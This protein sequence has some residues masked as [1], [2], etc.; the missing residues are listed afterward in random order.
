M[1]INSSVCGSIVMQYIALFPI[2]FKTDVCHFMLIQREWTNWGW[3]TLSSRLF[4]Q[5]S[6]NG[7]QKMQIN[8]TCVLVFSKYFQIISIV[9]YRID[10]FWDINFKCDS[11]FKLSYAAILQ[12][13]CSLWNIKNK[14]KT[15]VNFLRI[16]YVPSC[17]VH[18]MRKFIWLPVILTMILVIYIAKFGTMKPIDHFVADLRNVTVSEPI[19][20][21]QFQ[22]PNFTKEELDRINAA[23]QC[24]QFKESS[25]NVQLLNDLEDPPPKPDKSI[26]FVITTCVNDSRVTLKAR[27]LNF[28]LCFNAIFFLKKNSTFVVLGF[29]VWIFFV[30]K[31][32]ISTSNGLFFSQRSLC[33]WISR[34]I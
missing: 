3:L 12:A 5:P 16:K 11:I 1:A 27:Y 19:D 23:K 10:L 28:K 4:V 13:T 34:K 26:F 2:V 33:S 8:A 31:C 30:R 15:K 18:F 14:M 20:V 32:P 6:F 9:E 24:Y 22:Y 29:F 17:T 21:P 25:P 7:L